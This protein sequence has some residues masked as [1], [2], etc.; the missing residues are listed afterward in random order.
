M[1]GGDVFSHRYELVA[2]QLNGVAPNLTRSHEL[3]RLTRAEAGKLEAAGGPLQGLEQ[4][5]S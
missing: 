4:E 5:P 3:Q 2:G 1:V